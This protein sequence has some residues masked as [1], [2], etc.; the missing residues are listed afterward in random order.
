VVIA[1]DNMDCFVS[2]FER[3]RS[4]RRHGGGERVTM[5]DW[6]CSCDDIISS[7]DVGALK[8]DAHSFFG[9][10]LAGHGMGFGDAVLVDDR[11][12][13]CA[14]FVAA[15]GSAI[16]WKM[17]TDDLGAAVTGLRNWLAAREAPIMAASPGGHR[18]QPGP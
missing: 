1:T 16:E 14:A 9:P 3:A 7:S 11:T 15:G 6:A 4:R 18:E 2:A 13:N 12:A 10:W 8:E 17:G 5:A